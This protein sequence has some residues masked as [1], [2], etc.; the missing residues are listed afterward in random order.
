MIKRESQ[1]QYFFVVDRE[2]PMADSRGRILEHRYI[3][4]NH[5][6]RILSQDEVVHHKDG[7]CKNNSLN[8]LQLLERGEHTI[9]H[10]PTDLV[11]LECYRCGIEFERARR[12]IRNK[13]QFCSWKCYKSMG[14][15]K[16]K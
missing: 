7:N 2:H 8:N 12:N 4:S 3:M 5:L 15:G 10:Q 1:G 9:L 11:I 14:K 13:R 6:S 16:K